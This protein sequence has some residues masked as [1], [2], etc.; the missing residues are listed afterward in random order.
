[1]KKFLYLLGVCALAFTHAAKADVYV[2][3]KGMTVNV[4]NAAYSDGL[5]VGA[6][7]GVDF[8]QL[9]SNPVALELDFNTVLDE[10]KVSGTKWDTQTTAVYAAMRTGSDVYLKAKLGFHSTKTTV[11]AASG[12][13]S[14]LAYG[15]GV[16]FSDYIIEYTILK[17]ETSAGSDITLLSFGF[18]F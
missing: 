13:T 12:T 1:M 11:G 5:N 7:F 10:G 2:A 6:M 16:G 4:D 18:L 14:D 3:V 9:G 8:T 17:P 15:F